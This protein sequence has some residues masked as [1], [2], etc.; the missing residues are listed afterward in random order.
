MWSIV[1]QIHI[2]SSCCNCFC[3]LWWDCLCLCWTTGQ[4]SESFFFFWLFSLILAISI[5]IN[6]PSGHSWNIADALV[7]VDKVAYLKSACNNLWFKPC[8]VITGYLLA[9][10]V[11]GP[12]GFSFVSEMVQVC[13]LQYLL[14]IWSYHYC[15]FASA[16]CNLFLV[17][18]SWNLSLTSR[19][20]YLQVE[21]VAQFG[22]IFLLFALGLEFSA[23]KVVLVVYL[24]LHLLSL[25]FVIL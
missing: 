3:N 10:S 4:I 24:Y 16:I 6:Y 17:F 8:Q 25:F 18:Q 11:I 21:T 2:R 7:K 13:Y 12:G 22:V 9:G 15:I 5:F 14:F 1:L 23:V 20:M 19:S